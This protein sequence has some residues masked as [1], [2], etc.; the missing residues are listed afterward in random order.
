VTVLKGKALTHEGRRKFVE[1]AAGGPAPGPSTEW[2]GLLYRPFKPRTL[3]RAEEDTVEITLIPYYAW[4]NRGL[5][6]MEV[7]IPLAR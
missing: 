4:A 1:G 7:W 5:S 6:M 2:N 3:R